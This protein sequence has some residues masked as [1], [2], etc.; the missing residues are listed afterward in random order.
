VLGPTKAGLMPS[1]LGPKTCTIIIAVYIGE[2]INLAIWQIRP[3]ALF[4]WAY[5]HVSG[6]YW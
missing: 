4:S 3:N 5:K 1:F 6:L 2:V